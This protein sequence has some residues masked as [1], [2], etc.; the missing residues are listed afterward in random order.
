MKI[1]FLGTGE[2]TASIRRNTSLLIE[3]KGRR[4]LL[5]CGFTSAQNALRH[6]PDGDL[7]SLWISHFHGDHYFGIPQLLLHMY[8]KGRRAPLTIL[9]GIDCRQN[10]ALVVELAYP[11]LLDK[12]QFPLDYIAVPAISTPNIDALNHNGLSWQCALASHTQPAFSLLLAD[13]SHAIYYSGDGKPTAEGI[14]LMRRSDLV[15]QEA[16]SLS[17]SKPDHCSIKECGEIAESLGISTMALVHL[18]ST[19]REQLE[20]D[21]SL[22][23][24]LPGGKIFLPDDDDEILL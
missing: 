18:E 12:I 1:T 7:D 14:E 19:T 23:P 11:G 17:P 10:V 20:H 9:G 8:T 3:S 13:S 24:S 6:C 21:D 2:A 15:I 22:L 16:F 4:H 5:D